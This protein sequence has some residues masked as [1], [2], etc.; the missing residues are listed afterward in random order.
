[1]GLIS[2]EG[3]DGSGKSTQAALLAEALGAGGERPLVLREPGGT[4]A[5]ERVR[6][7]LTEPG[8]ELTPVA[9]LLLFCAARAELVEREIRP[10]LESGRTVIC[11]R[12]T[13]STVAY[14][15][16]ARGLGTGTVAAVNEIATGGL[17]PDLTLYLRIEPAEALARAEREDR[18]E[19][20]GV[21]LQAAVAR[22]YDEIA[23]AEPGRVAVIDAAAP[24]EQVAEAVLERVR[25]LPRSSPGAAEGG[26]R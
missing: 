1:M 14:Q 6:E 26:E 20:E 18:F 15:G 3:V 11:D 4:A 22:G 24:R 7:I 10:A 9:E 25:Q 2:F 19:S 23:A 13:D 21:E 8:A 5:A 12:F 16:A 17:R